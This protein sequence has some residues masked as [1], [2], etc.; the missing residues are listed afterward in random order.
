VNLVV[1][2]LDGTLA[3]TN[4][5]DGECYERALDEA[6]RISDLDTNWTRY[7]HVT[8]HGIVLQ[9]FAERFGRA[10]TAEESLRLVDRFMNL[11]RQRCDIDVQQCM[12]VP[13]AGKTLTQ[14]KAGDEWGVA[15][16]TGAWQRSA[17]FKIERARLPLDDVPKAYSEDGPSRESIVMTAITRAAARYR[18]S[19]FNRIVSVG[20]AAW[21]V[22]TAARLNLPFLGIARGERA[23]RL[24]SFGARDVIGDFKDSAAF[25]SCLESAAPPEIA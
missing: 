10:P 23:H 13:G 22:R 4:R 19:S 1:F 17:E 8:D 25:L 16:A 7:D 3:L 18:Q 5:V 20:D 21:D 6:L 2:D 11:L 15:L 14:L 12:E 24:R 9:I